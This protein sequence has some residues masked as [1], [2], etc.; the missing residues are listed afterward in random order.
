MSD[1]IIIYGPLFLFLW[2]LA[3]LFFFLTVAFVQFISES[4]IH[5]TEDIRALKAII[6]DKK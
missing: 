2:I 4:M 3:V 6:K 5:I 1:N